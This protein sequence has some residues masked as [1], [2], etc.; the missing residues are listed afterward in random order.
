M[1]LWLVEMLN[2]YLSIHVICLKPCWWVVVSVYVGWCVAAGV[3][4][5]DYA[6]VLAHW[7]ICIHIHT[8]NSIFSKFFFFFMQLCTLL[9][10]FSFSLWEIFWSYTTCIIGS[11]EWKRHTPFVPLVPIAIQRDSCYSS[12]LLME[13]L[14]SCAQATCGC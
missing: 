3:W 5:R 7:S 10:C 2:T 13:H 14:H 4:A 1:S 9:I 8:C 11:W 12:T 6:F